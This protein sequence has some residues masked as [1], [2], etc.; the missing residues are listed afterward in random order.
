MVRK[1]VYIE[2]RQDRALK[3]RAR[4]TGVTEAELVRRG[5]DA[6]DRGVVATVRDPDSWRA[7]RAYI[8]SH[9]RSAVPQTGRTWRRDELYEERLNA[10][11]R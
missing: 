10:R 5:I 4:A 2:A 6:L 9:R 11:P 7:A 8:A 3:R 1:Q